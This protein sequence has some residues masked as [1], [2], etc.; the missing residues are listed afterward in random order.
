MKSLIGV[1]VA[2]FFTLVAVDVLAVPIA[3]NYHY[4]P[5]NIKLVFSGRLDCPKDWTDKEIEIA[6]RFL[7][8]YFQEKTIE[9]ET[10]GPYIDWQRIGK[11]YYEYSRTSS[12]SIY[13]KVWRI[14]GCEVF[15]KV[16]LEV[17]IVLNGVVAV[18]LGFAWLKRNREIK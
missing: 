4:E 3:V 6:C 17:A 11:F 10:D 7:T 16:S 8:E 1:I 2:V 15:N 5:E 13:V 12:C 14:Y 9:E 18:S